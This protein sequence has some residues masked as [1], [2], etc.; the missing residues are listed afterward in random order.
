MSFFSLKARWI[1]L[2]VASSMVNSSSELV[3]KHN[4]KSSRESELQFA[5][6]GIFFFFWCD[7]SCGILWLEL[8]KG[9][10]RRILC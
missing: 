9:D 5:I 6:V 8:I 7:V 2:I 10:L 3:T 4:R 1:S